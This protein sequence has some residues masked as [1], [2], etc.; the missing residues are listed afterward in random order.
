MNSNN[1]DPDDDVP[2]DPPKLGGVIF[3][4]RKKPE[5]SQAVLAGKVQAEKR[6]LDPE[7]KLSA[8]SIGRYENGQRRPNWGTLIAMATVFGI[9][10]DEMIRD[11]PEYVE[12]SLINDK[13]K[14]SGHINEDE[15]EKRL[16]EIVLRSGTKNILYVSA[17]DGLFVYGWLRKL[18]ARQNPQIAE[19][20][21]LRPSDKE[22][23]RQAKLG[24]ILP[25]MP[26]QLAT[27]MRSL[28]ELLKRNNVPLQELVVDKLPTY[29][30]FAYGDH[31]FYGNWIPD[32]EH[33]RHVAGPIKRAHRQRSSNEF[34]DFMA[35]FK[36]VRR[37]ARES[38]KKSAPMR[39]GKTSYEKPKPSMARGKKGGRKGATTAKRRQ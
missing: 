35:D 14:A 5:W 11:I 2:L 36:I 12:G 32:E 29:H 25:E 24:Y 31:L 37:I 15:K 28:K 33:R 17:G 27:N 8:A 7:A 38:P 20:H 10:V 13:Y 39:P 9:S 30:G 18:Y 23:K 21:V 16:T 1:R 3:G 6:K 26:R 19:V 22:M 4:L 34:N